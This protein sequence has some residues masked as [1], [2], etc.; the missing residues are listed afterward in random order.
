G[1]LLADYAYELINSYRV[2]VTSLAALVNVYGDRKNYAL[3]E[4]AG[5][6]VDTV[7]VWGSNPHA[8]T[9]FR[10]SPTSHSDTLLKT[11]SYEGV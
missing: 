9:I 10:F 2:R 4:L 6:G 8:P 5:D 11:L 7:G 3:Y 1:R